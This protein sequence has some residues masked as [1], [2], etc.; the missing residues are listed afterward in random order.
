MIIRLCLYTFESCIV[1][2]CSEFIQ[3]ETR[4]DGVD[5]TNSGDEIAT[6]NGKQLVVLFL[7]CLFLRQCKSTKT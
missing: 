1:N 2:S 7:C 4:L 3:G 5:L 6:D